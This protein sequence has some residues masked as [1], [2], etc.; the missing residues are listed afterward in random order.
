MASE[1]T[2]PGDPGLPITVDL[3]DGGALIAR[4]VR[5]DDADALVA[6]YAGLSDTDRRR[7]FF[8][9]FRATRAWVLD[10]IDRCREHGAGIVAEVAG[11]GELVGEAAY[12]ETPAGT[13]DFSLT[14]DA[15]WRGWLGPYLLDLLVAQAANG[16]SNLEADI[17]TDNRAMQAIARR[18]GAVIGAESDQTVTHVVVGTHGRIASWPDRPDQDGRLRV[19]VEVPGGRWARSPDLAAAGYEVL[20]CPGPDR[21]VEPCP[22]LAGEPCPLAAAADAIVV[23]M[24]PGVVEALTSG[25]RRVHPDVPLV[26]VGDRSADVDPVCRLASGSSSGE[27]LAALARVTGFPF[28]DEP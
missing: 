22:V 16:V 2:E 21:R 8:T 19:L 23:A 25:H 26:V 12:V 13:G 10:W 18:R 6:L 11:S 15:A 20:G 24:P 1:T 5:H 4:P 17:L 14:V 28:D 7:R 9:Q 27:L 3:P